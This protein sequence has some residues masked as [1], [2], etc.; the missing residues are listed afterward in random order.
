M[1]PPAN[2]VNP[3]IRATKDRA[4]RAANRA[5]NDMAN[6]TVLTGPPVEWPTRGGGPQSL[7]PVVNNT[8]RGRIPGASAIASEKRLA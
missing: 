7:A 4:N 6:D 1:P 5:A 3:L 2:K 8:I